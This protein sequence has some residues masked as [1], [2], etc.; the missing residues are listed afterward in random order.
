MSSD[1]SDETP[2]C[3]RQRPLGLRGVRRV[4]AHTVWE[5]T[6]ACNLDCVHCESAAGAERPA[7]LNTEE[8]LQVCEDLASLGCRDVNLSGGE[9]LLRPD[10]PLICERLAA[11]GMRPI[12][13]SNLTL[14]DERHLAM[15]QRVGVRCIG[16]SLD[17]PQQVH[18]RIRRVRGASFSPFE[19]T[20]R[21]ISTLKERGFHVS[22]VTH[23]SLWNIDHLDAVADVLEELGADLWQVQIGFP[24]GRLAE[25]ADEYLIYP[26]QIRRIYDLLVR[27]KARGKMRIDV[28]DDIGYFGED[29]AALR[30]RA[31][32]ACFWAGCMAGYRVLAIAAD[33]KIRGCPSLAIEVGDLRRT[34]LPEIWRDEQRFWFNACWDDAKLE[35]RCR[36]C[37]FRRIC[38]AGCKSLAYSTTGSI[39]R[40]IYCLNQVERLGGDPERREEH[41]RVLP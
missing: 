37:P 9:P 31:G 32:E 27:R 26:G 10:L 4:P 5:I 34:P 25:I 22:V 33:G 23:I 3:A 15:L 6:N 30:E 29:E 16:T 41:G 7:E 38:R 11:L 13:V 21:T 14:L 1:P 40:N 39:Y 24:E 20:I 35:G 8:A 18:D 2:A 12:V 19:R 36:A 17:G 28:A